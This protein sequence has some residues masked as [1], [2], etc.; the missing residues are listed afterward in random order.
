ML[1]A[2][3]LPFFCSCGASVALPSVSFVYTQMDISTVYTYNEEDQK[4]SL[5]RMFG[6]TIDRLLPMIS[7][8]TL[9]FA[10]LIET[11]HTH[12][13]MNESYARLLAVRDS[14]AYT[15]DEEEESNEEAD[16]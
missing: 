2:F 12:A 15:S 10:T 8:P 5:S 6:E 3:A 4:E 13:L 9:R 1:R 7:N 11:Q 14:L 16:L